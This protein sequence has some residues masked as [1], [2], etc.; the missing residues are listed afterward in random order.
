MEFFPS[1]LSRAESNALAERIEQ[2]IASRGWGLWAAELRESG[3][4]IGFVGL[5]QPSPA[6]P[7]SPCVEVG[8]RLAR[9]FWGRGLATEAARMALRTAFESVGLR[10]VFS[11]TSILNLRSRAVM[12]R[13]GMAAEPN[14][15]DHPNVPEGHRLREHF[16][17]RL[18]RSEW[19][20]RGA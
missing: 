6:I 16:A 13:L 9:P 4:F 1:A 14:T 3:E 10:E 20:A 7:Y 17:Y 5:E 15:F 18:T 12:V 19:N 2:S 8:W 11:F